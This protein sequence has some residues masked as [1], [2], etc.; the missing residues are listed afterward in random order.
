MMT[1]IGILG[2]AALFAL[3]AYAATRSDTRLEGGGSC[4][5]DV[6]PLDSCALQDDCDGC[7]HAKSASGW[8]PD[9]GMK[10]GMKDGDRR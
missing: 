8:W 9:D 3:L 5:G 1:L 4:H 6:G 2:A 10:D 7:G